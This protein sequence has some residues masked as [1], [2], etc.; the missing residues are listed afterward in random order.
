MVIKFI[1]KSIQNKQ[2]NYVFITQVINALIALIAGKL[3]ALYISPEDFGTYNIQFATYTFFSTLL[4]S[5][6]IQFI[7]TSNTTLLPKIGS[8]QYLYTL[9]YIIGITYVLFISF[10]YFYYNI[11]DVFFLVI[12]LL[13]IFISTLQS[14]LSDYLNIHN[15][16]IAFSKLSLVKSL[17][18]LVFISI[19]LVLG[20]KFMNHVQVLWMMQLAGVVMATGIFI[21]KYRVI[22]TTYKIAYK[23][24]LKKYL[25]FGT[26]LI[27]LALWSWV[28]NYFDRYAIEYFLG[29]KDVGIYNANYGVG[30]KFFLMLGPIFLVLLTP[31]VYAKTKKEVKKN[32]I[33]NYGIYYFILGVPLL[34]IIYLLKDIIGTLLLSVAYQDGFHIIFWIALS[35]FIMT[36]TN[37]FETIFYSEQN[38]K[39]ILL[40]NIISATINII[41]NILLIPTFGVMGA[42]LAT[43]IGFFTHF[44]FIYLNFN[45]L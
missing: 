17:S 39:V 28:N 4:I 45:R 43:C 44:I 6:F 26:P 3:I 19:F 8:S 25:R 37:L 27:F 12:F 7:K 31:L 21:S 13:F 2:R 23:T 29:F 24:F 30:S 42:A 34:L 16:I 22:K 41:L 18:G 32:T 14:I 1:K 38:T 9:V 10:L 5:P 35:F 36:F 40:G 20:M 11:F 33:K 15:Q